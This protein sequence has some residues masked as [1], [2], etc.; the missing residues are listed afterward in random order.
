MLPPLALGAG[1]CPSKSDL[2]GH[3]R[4]SWRTNCPSS[5]DL[6]PFF[7]QRPSQLAGHFYT[8]LR[9]MFIRT[10]RPAPIVTITCDFANVKSAMG[11]AVHCQTYAFVCQNTDDSDAVMKG[12]FCKFRVSTCGVMF[13]QIGHF[14]CCATSLKTPFL[15]SAR[16][17][18][19]N[20]MK[21]RKMTTFA[22]HNRSC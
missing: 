9:I 15:T 11:R 20:L 18:P 14:E 19:K 12:L 4:I 16:H 6:N 21:G 2:D 1:F 7:C 10:T 22:S 13:H 5:S 17:S 3:F 8:D